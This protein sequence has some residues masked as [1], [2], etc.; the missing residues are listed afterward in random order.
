MAKRK[1]GVNDIIYELDN[2]DIAPSSDDEVK[3][4]KINRLEEVNSPQPVKNG[5]KLEETNNEII[6]E[7]KSCE[8]VIKILSPANIQNGGKTSEVVVDAPSSET[9]KNTDEVDCV[10]KT[11]TDCCKTTILN[12]DIVID[13]PGN[14]DLGVEGCEN[15]T[16]LI[17]VRFRDNKLA[18]NYKEQI[19]A[20]MLNLIK[21]HEGES[22]ESEN[23]TDLELDIWPEDLI[24]DMPVL[25]EEPVDN[26]LFFVDTDPG[27]D[28]PDDI[29]RYS[30]ASTVISNNTPKEPTPP[31]ARRG[32]CFN[33]DGNHTLRDCPE[34]KDF[35]RIANKRKSMPVR[36]GRYHVE[37]DQKFGHLIPG[38]ISGHLRH[39]LGLK[40]HELP[41]YIYRMRLLG[42]PPGWLEEARISH[43][44]ITMFDSSGN[45]ILEPEEEEGEVSEPGSKDKFDI[46]KI[47]DFPGFNVPASPRYKDEAHMFGLPPI[48]EQDSKLSMLQ[49][50]A[51]NAM[52]AYKRKKLILF[53]SASNNTTLEGQAEMDLDS[54]DE[55]TVFPSVPPLP[56]E[57]PPPLPP[58]PP[59]E[60]PP[61]PPPS[62]VPPPPPEIP[63]PLQP[64][65]KT[66]PLEKPVSIAH[67]SPAKVLTP[68][69]SPV[70]SSTEH[71]KEDDKS[72]DDILEVP[73]EDFIVIDEDNSELDKSHSSDR[74]SP[75]LDDLEAKKQ[76]LL[77][78]L[79]VADETP[80]SH[81]ITI[82]DDD[83]NVKNNDV[84]DVD[85][86]NNDSVIEIADVTIEDEEKQE[87]E[88]L[89][90]TDANK[91]TID[92]TSVETTDKT[93]QQSEALQDTDNVEDTIT[94]N[95]SPQ[96][97]PSE[98]MDTQESVQL[99]STQECT[100][101]QP[102]A[103]SQDTVC[104]SQSGS[105][106]Q[107]SSDVPRTPD[108]KMGKVKGTQY[109]TP[110][111]NIASSYVKLPSDD[112]FAKD[113]CDVINF[114]NL[115]NSTG[116]YKKMSALLRIVKNKVDQI[117]ES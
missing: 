37:D 23:D 2:E 86:K 3:E 56:D 98:I 25:E 47:L 5:S 48:S 69:A 26:N 72:A 14:S 106:S 91:P 105:N 54:G 114:E 32:L 55:A 78:A 30:Q 107:E 97:V 108:T 77:D 93:E 35:V 79:D 41:L 73:M 49:Y 84:V 18:S 112:K 52:K 42:Y 117:Q 63:M 115:P 101:S 89:V 31:P 90:S 102:L 9:Q 80:A 13:S 59:P 19:K 50:L 60:D 10:K 75:S 29:P 74:A 94:I 51:P 99:S 40:R 76:L 17:T 87:T 45:A 15:R 100:S 24:E 4:P 1:A 34:P 104:S 83:E 11:S 6:N 7:D 12:E 57:A 8:E 96:S 68:K 82:S 111:M 67:S 20:F 53:P 64:P 66:D 22:L 43:S 61:P 65:E 62:Q 71:A 21:L 103:D 70:L 113:V 27:Y 44:G 28:R 81:D 58:P 92:N 46:K 16:P 110:V 39:A 95:D 38:R 88:I 109:G 116:K 33:C 85:G 36:V